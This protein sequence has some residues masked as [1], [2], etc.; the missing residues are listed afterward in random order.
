MPQLRTV[1]RR[2]RHWHVAIL[3]LA[4]G[5]VLGLGVAWTTSWRHASTVEE[6]R[7]LRVRLAEKRE[8]IA[9][10]RL[11]MAEVAAAVDHLARTA[12]VV[13]DRAEQVRRLAHMEESRDASPDLLH[14][15]SFAETGGAIVSEDAARTLEQLA[16]VEGETSSVG[17]SIAVLSA[18]LKDRPVSA[19]KGMPSL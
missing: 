16:W 12:A 9:R 8:L 19:S 14:L 5:Y 10:Q 2:A 13:G 18:L 17:D 7:W 11:E 3:L 1:L 15:T 6:M 4:T